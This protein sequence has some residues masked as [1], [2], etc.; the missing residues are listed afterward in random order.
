L[1]PR[2]P[3]HNP[4]Q[5]CLS[6]RGRGPVRSRSSRW[7]AD[8][9]RVARFRREAQIL[10]SLNHPHIAAVYGLHDGDGQRLLVLEF[11]DGE[12][13]EARLAHGRLPL[14]DALAIARQLAQALEAA[15]EKGI[16]ASTLKR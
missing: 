14:D 11:V 15:L 7:S 12:T 10:A 5:L 4:R 8:P 6:N 2:I 13:L 1:N 9:E 3:W 16:W